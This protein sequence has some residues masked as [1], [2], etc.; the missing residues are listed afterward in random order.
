MRR[1]K[2]ILFPE[3]DTVRQLEMK[4]YGLFKCAGAIF[5]ASL[6][7]TYFLSF[8]MWLSVPALVL[9]ILMIIVGM[10]W[11]SWLGRHPSRHVFCPYCASKNDVFVSK[12]EFHCDICDRLVQLDKKGE[13]IAAEGSITHKEY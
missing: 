6:I 3:F 12:Q 8:L 2:L 7:T 9:S 4:G 1:L 5:L 11:I 13:P 10:I